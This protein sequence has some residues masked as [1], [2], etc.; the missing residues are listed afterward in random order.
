[1]SLLKKLRFNRRVKMQLREKDLKIKQLEDSV[2]TILNNRK[3]DFWQIKETFEKEFIQ[4]EVEIKDCYESIIKRKE[5]EIA[6]LK[7]IITE[8]NAIVEGAKEKV[9]RLEI[10]EDTTSNKL[11]SAND[12]LI[13]GIQQLKNIYQDF[14]DYKRIFNVFE[15]KDLPKLKHN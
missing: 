1:M 9:L 4:R 13:K 3:K 5:K 6:R 8:N 14:S 2:E 11:N 7:N 12:Y 15:N 10:L